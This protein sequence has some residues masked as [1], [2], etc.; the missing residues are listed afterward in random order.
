MSVF[1]TKEE[2]EAKN[3][4]TVELFVINDEDSVSICSF[5][6]ILESLNRRWWSFSVGDDV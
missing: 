1:E 5:I 2:K 6:R 3:D 4:I